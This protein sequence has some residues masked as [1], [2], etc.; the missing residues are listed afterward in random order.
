MKYM[1]DGA[2]KLSPK[3]VLC[4]KDPHLIHGKV[5]V[6]AKGC[7]TGKRVEGGGCGGLVKQCPSVIPPYLPPHLPT[8]PIQRLFNDDDDDGDDGDLLSI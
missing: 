2:S 4:P 8:S 3:P 6:T 1:P 5:L 7:H